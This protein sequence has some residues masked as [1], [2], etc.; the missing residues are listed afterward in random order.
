MIEAP[1]RRS[2]AKALVSQGPNFSFYFPLT[3]AD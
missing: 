2:M 1:G 3:V